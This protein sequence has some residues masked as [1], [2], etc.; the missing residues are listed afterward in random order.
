MR[1]RPKAVDDFQ[2]DIPSYPPPVFIDAAEH[3]LCRELAARIQRATGHGL[4]V[5]ARGEERLV[6]TELEELLATRGDPDDVERFLLATARRRGTTPGSWSWCLTVLRDMPPPESARE[7][8]PSSR[9]ESL[10]DAMTP[11]LRAEFEAEKTRLYETV[12]SANLWTSEQNRQLGE[13]EEFLWA[14]WSAKAGP[15]MAAG[16]A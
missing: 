6:A 16:G 10:L 13:A 9:W 5:A 3:P 1:A 15:Q 7:P 11:A 14:K 2:R 4:V 12:R 8:S